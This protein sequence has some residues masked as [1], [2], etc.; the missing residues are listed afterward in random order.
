M[1][2]RFSR[3][4]FHD[5][6]TRRS[7]GI[8]GDHGGRAII[9]GIPRVIRR[10]RIPVGRSHVLLQL[11]WSKETFVAELAVVAVITGVNTHVVVQVI[12]A[13][14]A[15]V[16]VF[17]HKWLIFGVCEQVPLKLVFTVERLHASS[18]TA[19]GASERRSGVRVMNQGMPL[20][21]I[22]ACESLSAFR[23]LVFLFCGVHRSFV[24]AKVR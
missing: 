21:F 20:H 10:I 14:V 8:Q 11:V 13:C 7:I 4:A 15:F 9:R 2:D 24:R 1:T 6:G 22:S 3:H 17:T 18:V 23:T 19:E 5:G 12:T 16:A